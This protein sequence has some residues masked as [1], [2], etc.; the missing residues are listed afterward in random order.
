MKTYYYQNKNNFIYETLDELKLFNL[1][2]HNEI[3]DSFRKA[4]IDLLTA[5]GPLEVIRKDVGISNPCISNFGKKAHSIRLTERLPYKPVYMSPTEYGINEEMPGTLS[6]HIIREDHIRN[7]FTPAVFLYINI[8]Y[9]FIRD[10]MITNLDNAD[11]KKYFKV[12]NNFPDADLKRI[13]HLWRQGDIRYTEKVTFKKNFPKVPK[14][15]V[16][17]FSYMHYT[18]SK[19]GYGYPV[20]LNDS[21]L[22]FFDG[23]HRLCKSAVVQKD[24]PLLIG[25]KNH[26][27]IINDNILSITPPWFKNNQIAL[28][29]IN[30]K[31]KD[32]H[33]WFL[34]K[35]TAK[36]FTDVQIPWNKKPNHIIDSEY[37]KKLY[38]ELEE[39][40]SDFNFKFKV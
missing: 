5:D 23:S 30:Y 36:K 33:G 28:F 11:L 19:F 2:L 26:S 37:L 3:S 9:M 38:F 1:Y 35:D 39:K 15:R 10:N 32:I 6:F 34:N 31:N 21:N 40:P 22:L 8:P 14:W 13:V 7:L 27:N 4:E 24:Y 25:L 17:M 12:F 18:V 16:G 29:S 20:M